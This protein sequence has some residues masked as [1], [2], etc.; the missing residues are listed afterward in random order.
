MRIA[1]YARAETKEHKNIAI[2]I[3]AIEDLAQKRGWIV[4]MTV[5]ETG[6]DGDVKAEREYIFKACRNHRI[7]GIAV[8]KIDRW[9]SS[10]PDLI[11]TLKELAT[12]EVPL[13]SVAENFDSAKANSEELLNILNQFAEREQMI[14]VEKIKTG[15]QNSKKKVGRPQTAVRKAQRVIGLFQEGHSKAAIA[16]ILNI[17]RAS[18]IRILDEKQ[19]TSLKS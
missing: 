4:A 8:W 15:L 12:L 7:D 13:Y 3:K 9:A 19:Y 10:L 18:V 14:A 16:R 5:F 17:S 11:L 6:Q 1:I 2:Q